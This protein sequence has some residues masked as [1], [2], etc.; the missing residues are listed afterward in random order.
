MLFNRTSAVRLLV[1]PAT[2]FDKAKE[3]AAYVITK[4][5][6]ALAYTKDRVVGTGT[7]AGSGDA[8]APTTTAT[9]TATK[10]VMPSQ[11]GQAAL[12]RLVSKQDS[13]RLLA[14]CVHLCCCF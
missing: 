12:L 14:A 5:Q 4:A 10:D 1:Q 8:G 6:D 7:A 9:T 2:Y 11:L 3:G 13:G